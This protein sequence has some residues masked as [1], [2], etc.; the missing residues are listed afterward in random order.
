MLVHWQYPVLWYEPR[1]ES[2]G[3][4]LS[5]KGLA[6]WV[7]ILQESNKLSHYSSDLAGL[8]KHIT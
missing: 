8:R 6:G 3:R 1:D 5:W 7:R 2:S 4:E